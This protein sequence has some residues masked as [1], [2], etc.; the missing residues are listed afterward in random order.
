MS[1]CSKCGKKLEEGDIYCPDCGTK[2]IEVNDNVKIKSQ[3]VLNV[4]T[5]FKIIV[6]IL[7]NMFLKPITTAKK[8]INETEKNTVIMLTLFLA[9][10]QG[11]L[12]MWRI[13]QI[14][15]SITNIVQDITRKIVGIINLI[16]PQD[17][18]NVI[19]DSQINEITIEIS[20][21]KSY[22]KIPYGE[23]FL[24][25][26]ALVLISVLIIFVIICVANTLLSKKAP[27]RFKYYKTALIV[28]VPTLYFEFFSIIFS[29]LSIDL[30]LALAL[31]GYIFSLICFAMVI[32]ES[33]VISK[34]YTV[35][36]VSVTS[37][38]TIVVLILCFE[39][40]M[41]SILSSIVSS[42]MNDIKNLRI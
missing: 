2:N 41:P 39:G 1:Y 13:S 26:C 32:D 23:I 34:D 7:V 28:I 14:V 21:I 17:S 30:G 3:T 40:F 9:A 19:S 29:Y 11:L 36:V 31:L 37:L 27:E 35:Y 12:G 22:I 16:Q 18:S 25:N 33:L 8:F 10:M 15:S 20:K 4:D 24:Q 6:N 38:V 42:I 5:N